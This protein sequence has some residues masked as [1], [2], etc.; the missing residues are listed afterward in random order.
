MKN[1]YDPAK[2]DCRTE[3]RVRRIVDL[4][5][6]RDRI[7]EGPM[8]DLEALAVLAGDY[9]AA[10]M[11]CAAAELRKRFDWY[12]NIGLKAETIQIEKERYRVSNDLVK[13]LK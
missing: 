12:S 1:F 6:R 9:E 11:P 7:L 3:E 4:S 5:R 10:R 13:N 2:L 8:L